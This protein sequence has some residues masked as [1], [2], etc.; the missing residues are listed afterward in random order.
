MVN[1]SNCTLDNFICPLGDI[2]L[3]K[4]FFAKANARDSFTYPIHGHTD[5]FS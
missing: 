3:D 5:L 2:G 4:I 1:S